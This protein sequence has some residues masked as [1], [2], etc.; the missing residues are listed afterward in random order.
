M[1]TRR[2][3]LTAGATT[4]AARSQAAP[5]DDRPALLGGT[6]AHAG[7]FPPWPAYDAREE[8]AF[9]ET[10]KSRKWHRVGGQNV[11]RFEQAFA[12]I[13]GAKGCVA[14]SSGTAALIVS[15]KALG[16][17]PG[18]EVI[19]PPYTFIATINA[20]LMLYA[21]PVFVDS[22]FETA[23]IDAAKIEAAMTDRTAAILPVHL[24]GSAA[25]L[26]ALLTIG[27]RRG[28]PVIEDACQAHLGEWRKRKLGS[29]GAT[30]CFSFQT[31]KNMAC[32]EGGALISD[33][34]ALLEKCFAVHSHGRGR[35]ATSYDF[36]YSST[37]AN[38][39][40][41]EFHAAMASVQLS[42]I[43][44]QAETRDRNAEYLA[45]LFQEI[46]GVQM[47][48]RYPGCTRSAWHLFIFRY[49]REAFAGLPKSKVVRALN[50]EG[51]PAAG[52]YG[53]LN[54]ESFLKTALA[55]RPFQSIY[56]KERLARWHER[57]E[58][59]ENDRL[60]AEAIW[61]PQNTLLGKRVDME[62]IAEAMRK[63]QKHA[64]ALA[65]A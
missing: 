41:D 3:L 54:K 4:M 51:I 56:S 32:G 22:D 49:R 45:R 62:K 53:P 28:I 15:L 20:V 24:G 43:E 37:G 26:D 52:G 12:R 25:D 58:C 5:Y 64:A 6:P 38:F 21:L 31:S 35:K 63:T 17:G 23:Q 59:P 44:Q 47:A 36:T 11:N 10:L 7:P 50:A 42:R 19:V 13:M 48:R 14:T 57:N 46:P 33:D 18:D 61:L 55:G 34:E 30:G 2:H 27:Q 9:E 16:V 29:L 39:R 60:C 40:M 1:V 8:Q 65:K